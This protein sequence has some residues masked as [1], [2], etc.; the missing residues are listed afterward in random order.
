MQVTNGQF[1]TI[2]FTFSHPAAVNRRILKRIAAALE[3]GYSRITGDMGNVQ[4]PVVN[5]AIHASQEAFKEVVGFRAQGA[6]AGIGQIHLARLKGFSKLLTSYKQLA[7][8]EFTHCATLNLIINNDIISG[9]T[10]DVE[11]WALQNDPPGGPGFNSNYPRWLWESV[12]CY[13]AGQ[14]SIIGLFLSIIN[15]FPTL[16]KINMHGSKVYF[17]GYSL[18]EFIITKWGRNVFNSL[19][20]ERGNI[21]KVLG[22]NEIEL[23]TAYR[24]FVYTRYFGLYYKILTLSSRLRSISLL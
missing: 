14:R 6:I 7:L 19:I 8:H 13:E 2:H 3:G 12:A 4:L 10:K 20:K 5:V 22:V 9:R 21:Q 18:A 11:E 1:K 15:G 16:E 24:N 23:H 17:M